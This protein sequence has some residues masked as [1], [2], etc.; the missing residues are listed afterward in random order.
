MST[1]MPSNQIR[2]AVTW[3]KN[4]T[5]IKDGMQPHAKH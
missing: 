1:G 4:T 5:W 2:E 3:L